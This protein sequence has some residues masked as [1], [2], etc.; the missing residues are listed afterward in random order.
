MISSYLCP[1]SSIGDIVTEQKIR[2]LA[3]NYA[4]L[5]QKYNDT[6]FY[7]RWYLVR[8]CLW[9]TVRYNDKRSG[10]GSTSYS[11]G[12]PEEQG[13]YKNNVLVEEIKKDAPL[14]AMRFGKLQ[15][16]TNYAVA[17]AEKAAETAAL[18][19]DVASA[20]FIY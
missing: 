17:E 14:F 15:D 6:T 8:G 12:R 13:R 1:C 2:R 9:T 19:A 3:N 7:S 18:K 4:V 5:D 11:D 10:F 16:F 20:R